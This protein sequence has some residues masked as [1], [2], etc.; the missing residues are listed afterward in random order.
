MSISENP[1]SLTRN[2]AQ[3]IKKVKWPIYIIFFVFLNYFALRNVF[4][5]SRD[6]IYGDFSAQLLFPSPIYSPQRIPTTSLTSEYQAANR[7]GADFASIYFP[8]QEITSLGNAYTGYV[9][10]D[11]WKRLP[12]YAPLVLA[13]C[14]VTLCKLDYGY[15]AFGNILIQLLLF[16]L[17][18]YLVS[19]LIGIK[20][21][22]LLVF[23]FMEFCL[24]LT[25]AGLSWFERGQFSLYM[26]IAYLLLEL[27][28]TK[29]NTILV[30]ISAA[31]AF[32]KWTS[33]PF[34]F[35]VLAVYILNSKTKKELQYSLWAA[36]L[37]G[38]VFAIF[39][40]PF[41]NE[42][43]HFIQLLIHLESHR[44]PQGLSLGIYIPNTVVKTLPF[45]LSLIGLVVAKI[46]KNDFIGLFPF[47]TGVAVILLLYPTQAFEY[48]VPSL[49][50][51][52]PL[53]IIWVKQFESNQRAIG[54][55]VLLLFLLFVVLASFS[56]RLTGSTPM[57][58]IIY[59]AFSIALMAVPILFAKHAKKEELNC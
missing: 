50:G 8:A 43:I 15:A 53:M 32:I 57:M 23:L 34:I 59:L 46:N 56:T 44:F 19:R 31:F 36:L 27:G 11:P 58:V 22:F 48:S 26:A 20:E 21:Y 10:L 28:L 9:S 25:P 29:N 14:S 16:F 38:L 30:V 45:G 39:L 40:L 5:L 37:F 42:N 7:L 13:L 24:F 33:L 55:L 3:F 17:V 1:E 52:I 6:M 2:V 12:N 54:N 18:I 47:L 41:I 35:V 51:L 4:L 49:L